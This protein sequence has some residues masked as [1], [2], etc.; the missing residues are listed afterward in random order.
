MSEVLFDIP[1]Q[2]FLLYNAEKDEITVEDP[3]LDTTRGLKNVAL[4]LER[5]KNIREG[6]RIERKADKILLR[7][8]Y[9]EERKTKKEKKKTEKEEKLKQL[10]QQLG[11]MSRTFKDR[12][13]EFEKHKKLPKRPQ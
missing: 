8:K 2:G 7:E 5:K 11:S 6:K 9:Q 10:E 1:T 4:D 13:S 3:Y 12:F